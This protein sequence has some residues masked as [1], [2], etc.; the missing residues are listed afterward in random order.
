M[1]HLSVGHTCGV[2]YQ[3]DVC[4][5]RVE[6]CHTII[7]DAQTDRAAVR[8]EIEVLRRERLAYEQEGME[9]RQ[10]LARSEA[11]CR[12]LEAR[13]TVLETEVR[14]KSCRLGQATDDSCVQH[15][16][17]YPGLDRLLLKC[18]WLLQLAGGIGSFVIGNGTDS[19]SSGRR[20]YF[21]QGIEA[22]ALRVHLPDFMKVQP[23]YFKGTEGVV[24]VNQWDMGN[25]NHINN[26]KGTG[27]GQKPTC[28]ECGVQGHF[29]KECPRLKNNKGNRG[30]QAGND[31][32]P[33]KVY[34]VGNAGANPDNVVAYESLN[35]TFDE[36]P[37][38]SKTSPLL[39]DDLDE[40]EAIKVTEK[41]NL[42]NDIEDETLKIDEIVNIKES[43]NHPL[44]N[45][46][47]NL[48]QRTLRS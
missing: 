18:L 3:V 47:G 2:T 46:I 5:G 45:V 17:P 6:C 12:A 28:F 29:Q 23:L 25:A 16:M 38:P 44:E 36:T 10:A 30:N 31:R 43:R 33:A 41:K 27:S 37:P 21:C 9:T 8:A 48:N 26:Q 39:D 35:V 42:E 11:H 20:V 40:E 34:V 22:V 32:A 4:I 15:I 13:V 7:H 19:H 14:R 1:T 24:E